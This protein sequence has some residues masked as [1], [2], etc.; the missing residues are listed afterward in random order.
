MTVFVA[1]KVVDCYLADTSITKLDEKKLW[2]Y[3]L[4]F[5]L[6]EIYSRITNQTIFSIIYYSLIYIEVSFAVVQ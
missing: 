3:V 4:F 2:F 1:D 6:Q 5:D